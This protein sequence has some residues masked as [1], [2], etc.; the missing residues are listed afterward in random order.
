MSDGSLK[1]IYIQ[2]PSLSCVFHTIATRYPVYHTCF[3]EG[4]YMQLLPDD[5]I[6]LYTLLTP[7][8]MY[9]LGECPLGTKF[10]QFNTWVRL[11]LAWTI[12]H[13]VLDMDGLTCHGQNIIPNGI[14]KPQLY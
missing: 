14:T 2:T 5:K 6:L 13:Y 3:L 12:Q 7:A 11:M 1:H 4:G 8:I 9:K 10:V